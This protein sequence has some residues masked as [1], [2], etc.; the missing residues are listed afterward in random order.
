MASA[1][2]TGG[3]SRAAQRLVVAREVVGAV[4]VEIRKDRV[5]ALA[6]EVAFFVQLS[7]LPMVLVLAALLGL[8]EPL[9]AADLA[10]DAERAITDALRDALGS[11]DTA[12]VEAVGDLFAESSLGILTFGALGALWS[13]SKAFAGLAA[14]LDVVYG[15]EEER[16]WLKLRR[17]ALLLAMGTAVVVALGTFALVAGPLLGVG[18]DVADRLGA[19]DG[20]ARAW[21]LLQ[22]PVA[23]AIAVAWLVTLL[24][25][26][27]DHRTPWRS[28]LPGAVLAAVWWL[29]ATFGLR[30]YLAIAGDGNVVYGALG[31]VLSFS[32]WIYLLMLGVLVGGELN[33]VLDDRRAASSSGDP[34]I[35]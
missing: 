19:G 17:D 1:G 7:V 4:L 14:A 32:L 11:D 5:T 21:N 18:R 20:F 30:V 34:T 8:L 15:L 2:G 22:V 10:A 25:A 29:L 35:S 24:H 23:A 33:Q 6:A 16:S 13:G 12:L 3:G 27:P 31:G 28:D 26:A 9:G